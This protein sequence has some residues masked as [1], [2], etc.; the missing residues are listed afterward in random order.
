MSCTAV[1]VIYL[2]LRFEGGICMCIHIQNEK[3]KGGGG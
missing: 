2:M 1:T 3:K